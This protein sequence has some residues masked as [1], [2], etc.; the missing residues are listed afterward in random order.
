MLSDTVHLNTSHVGW[1]YRHRVERCSQKGS[2]LDQT[3]LPGISSPLP[4]LRQHVA[5]T[6][7][8]LLQIITLFM[9]VQ[10]SR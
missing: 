3:G 2:D 4:C 5:H 8:T 1:M 9:Q 6:C 7:M 10:D